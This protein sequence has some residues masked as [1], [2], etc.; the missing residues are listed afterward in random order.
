MYGKTESNE[1][2]PPLQWH[3]F[4]KWWTQFDTSKAAPDQV[5]IWFEG[6]PEFL[7]PTDP[8]TSL[9]LNQKSQLAAFLASSMSKESLAKNLKEVLQILQEEEEECSSS[10][11]EEASSSQ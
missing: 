7:K 1:Q 2:F 5:K 6:H 3:A 4:I 8:E 9:F 10:N 11:K